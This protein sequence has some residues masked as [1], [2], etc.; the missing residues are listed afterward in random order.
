MKTYKVYLE[1]IAEDCIYNVRRP[2]SRRNNQTEK[3]EDPSAIFL[4]DLCS[5]MDDSEENIAPGEMPTEQ[6]TNSSIQRKC[7]PSA[8]KKQNAISKPKVQRE[9]TSYGKIKKSNSNEWVK[10]GPFWKSPK[11]APNTKQR[12]PLKVTVVTYSQYL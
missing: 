10:K 4:F 9:I 11:N 5:D 6:P 8:G 3:K 7:S 2:R 12:P 1:F